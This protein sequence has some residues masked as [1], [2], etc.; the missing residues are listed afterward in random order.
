MTSVFPTLE[1]VRAVQ[2]KFLQFGCAQLYDAAPEHTVVLELPLIARTPRNRVA[3]PVFPVSTDNDMLPCLLGL[4]EAPP[5]SVLFIHNSAERPLAVAGD[6]YV[7]SARQQ[8]LNGLIVDGAVRDVDFLQDLDFP[9]FSRSVTYVAAKQ[10]DQ[11]PPELPCAVQ[12]GDLLLEPGD[13]IF[14]DSDGLLLIKR[15]NLGAVFNGAILVSQREEK[16]KAGILA[17]STL[18]ELSG[19]R[20]FV[21][22]TGQ[23]RFSK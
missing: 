19:L 17:G 21:S 5:G 23:L 13:W 7:I 16:L 18:A 4:A 3:G 9:V 2:Q 22:G 6:I 1:R 8:G 12:L 10:T 14:G 11:R 15:K 20:E